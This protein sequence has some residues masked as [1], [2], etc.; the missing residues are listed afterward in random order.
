MAKLKLSSAYK[1]ISA[2]YLGKPFIRDNKLRVGQKYPITVVGIDDVE[3]FGTVGQNGGIGGL[4]TLYRRYPN[5]PENA[6]L[7]V[8]FDGTTVRIQPPGAAVPLPKVDP[9]A[10][11]SDYVL[12]RKSARRIYIPPYAPE[13]LNTWEPK[14]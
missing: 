10:P 8:T 6:E 9:A 4:G 11:P 12:D 1:A 5:L 14:G 7:E 13:M 3:L 2:L